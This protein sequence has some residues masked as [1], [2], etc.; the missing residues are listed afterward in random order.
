MTAD[1][2]PLRFGRRMRVKQGRD[3]A[4]IRQQGRRLSCGCLIANWQVLPAGSQTR[5]GVITTKKLGNAVIRARARRLLREAFRLEQHQLAAPVDLV[6]VAQRSIV[7]KGLA[8]VENDLLVGL[9]PGRGF[10]DTMNLAPAHLDSRRARLSVGDF[11]HEND[12]V[13]A[14]GSVPFRAKLLAL[15]DRCAANSRR[16]QRDAAGSLA[17]LP[18]PPLGRLRG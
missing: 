17:G 15:R 3:F 13:R 14:V 6:L 18:L 5:L 11:A 12:I 1:S 7:G 9:S 8:V 16:G 10:E 4:R 2:P